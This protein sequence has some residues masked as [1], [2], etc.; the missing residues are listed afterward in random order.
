MEAAL[1]P[2]GMDG[3]RSALRSVEMGQSIADCSLRSRVN[4]LTPQEAQHLDLS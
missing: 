1:G 3:L 2:L 4:W